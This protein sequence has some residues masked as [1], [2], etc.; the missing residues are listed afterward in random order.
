M[1]DGRGGHSAGDLASRL[2]IESLVAA[3]A[4]SARLVDAVAEGNLKI[5]AAARSSPGYEGMDT[6]LSAANF[7]A[8]DAQLVVAHVGDSREDW[9]SK[10]LLAVNDLHVSLICM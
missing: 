1:A 5:F 4:A 7:A 3:M 10:S 2:A 8:E 6:T 9:T